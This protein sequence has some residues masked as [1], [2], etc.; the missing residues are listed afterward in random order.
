MTG[1]CVILSFGSNFGD[2]KKN[3]ADALKWFGTMAS[4]CRFSSIYETP[5]VHGNGAAYMNAVALGTTSLDLGSL[6]KL[7]KTFELN[8]GRDDFH[9]SRG[10]VPIDIDVVMW[11][12]ETLR[13]MDFSCDFFQIGYREIT[14]N[15]FA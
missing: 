13:P 11:D 4:D 9:R 12:N 2:R 3:V 10:E 1:S 7:A 14:D 8:N 6:N 15:V 5:E